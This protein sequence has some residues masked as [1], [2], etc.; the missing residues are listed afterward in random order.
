MAEQSDSQSSPF[1]RCPPNNRTKASFLA[2]DN[3]F[4]C[5]RVLV[6]DWQENAKDLDDQNYRFAA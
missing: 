3:R 4:T 2:P 5:P 6:A 1:R